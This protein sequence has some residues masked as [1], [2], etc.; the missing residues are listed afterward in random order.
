[1]PWRAN[2]IVYMQVALAVISEGMISN[3]KDSVTQLRDWWME[4]GPPCL[5]RRC[6]VA[7][8]QAPSLYNIILDTWPCPLDITFYK[9]RCALNIQLP[10][11]MAPCF[12]IAQFLPWSHVLTFPLIP[13][14][15]SFHN[16]TRISTW[17][18]ALAKLRYMASTDF[19]SSISL[20]TRSKCAMSWLRQVRQV[21]SSLGR[22]DSFPW[23]SVWCW[24]FYVLGIIP[25][26]RESH[27]INNCCCARLLLHF[28]KS[29]AGKPSDLPFSWVA[30]H[31]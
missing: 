1:M 7:I 25:L 2:Q 8:L 24:L 19:P 14:Y 28:V 30:R 21:Y 26:S 18:N 15:V 4:T 12:T 29:I 16:V 10:L 27:Q 22:P 17:S 23:G 5:R 20:V 9:S 3:M 13:I 11:I 6:H 31:S